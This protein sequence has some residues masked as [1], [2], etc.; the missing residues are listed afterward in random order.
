MLRAVVPTKRT[1]GAAWSLQASRQALLICV[2]V[3]RLGAPLHAQDI[4]IKVLNA[5]NGK[6]I[7]NECVNVFTRQELGSSTLLIPT[8]REGVALLHVEGDHAVPVGAP[9]GRRCGGSETLHPT[10][11]H[12]DTIQI[13][14]D[15]Y[16]ACQEYGKTMPGEG[17]G[18]PGRDQRM[19]SYSV[20]KILLSG[21]AAANTCGRF[22]AQ[23]K[24]GELILYVRPLSLLEKLRL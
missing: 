8:D 23:P 16:L 20:A 21:I 6:P 22:T 9:L 14:G 24:P 10:V 18:G 19:P 17:A 7:T 12:A 5:R 3:A 11:G 2:G 1:I 4:H 13:S 15:Y